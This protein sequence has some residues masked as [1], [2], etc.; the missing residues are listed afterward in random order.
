MYISGR[1]IILKN[2]LTT[3]GCM[4]SNG[5]LCIALPDSLNN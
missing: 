2:K 1:S 5:M 3:I 4:S